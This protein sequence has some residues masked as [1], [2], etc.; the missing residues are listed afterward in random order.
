MFGYL[1]VCALLLSRSAAFLS[2]SLQSHRADRVV[3]S[4]SQ[5]SARKHLAVTYGGFLDSFARP[6][7]KKVVEIEERLGLDKIKEI[8][9]ETGKA[10]RSQRTRDL[11]KVVETQGPAPDLHP[12]KPKRKWADDEISAV[13]Q[14]LNKSYDYKAREDLSDEERLGVIDWSAFDLHAEEL[15]PS[16]NDEESKT[17][18]K[19][20]SWLAYHR[21]KGDIIFDKETWVFSP[22]KGK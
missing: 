22:R 11:K 16:Y 6:R 12:I 7:P 20:K 8:T 17:R 4:S 9:T 2:S 19:V 3:V 13:I 21:R 14:V 10:Q 15:I 1:L 5:L 18:S